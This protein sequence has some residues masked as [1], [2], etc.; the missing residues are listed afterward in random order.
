MKISAS[1]DGGPRSRVRARGTLRSAPIGTSGNFLAHIDFTKFTHFAV[2][3][4]LIWVLGGV[5]QIFFLIEILIF[6]FPWSPCK[7]LK[8][9][10][11]PFWEKQPNS[12]FC[13]AKIGF[14]FICF[15]FKTQGLTTVLTRQYGWSSRLSFLL[16]ARTKFLVL[17]MN[18]QDLYCILSWQCEECY[19]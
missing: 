17:M 7:I 6:L 16:L 11:K 15:Y 19:L 12:A 8:L 2:K 3:I 14:Q 18:F 13:P 1:A 5:P 4:V 9:Q 10:H